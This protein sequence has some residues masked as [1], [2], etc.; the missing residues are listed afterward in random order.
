[1]IWRDPY[2]PDIAIPESLR[3][4]WFKLGD[5]RYQLLPKQYE[6]IAGPEESMAFIGGYGSGKTRV[7]TIKAAA[8]SCFT[9]SNRGIV[10]RLNGTDLEETTQRDLLDFLHE[11]K[12]LK[13]EPNAR[14]H[15]ALVHCI[16]EK[17]GRNLGLD[18][19][20][21]FQHLDDPAHLRGRHV[22]WVWI[23]EGSEVKRAAWQNLIGRMRL[24]S[25]RGRYRAF[26]TGNP[27]GH[28]WIYDFFFDEAK[29]K[30]ITCGG[31]PGAH[32]PMCVDHDDRKC[33]KRLRLQRR[34]IHCTSYENYFLPPEY[35]ESM[36]NSF[37][38]DERKRYVEASFDVFEGQVFKEFSHQTHVIQAPSS[39]PLGR[40]PK[41][42][43]RLLACDVGG[44]SPWSFEWCAVDPD[45]NIVFYD[46]IYEIT[47]NVDRLVEK[48]LPKMVDE[49]GQQYSFRSKVID[50]ENK[51]AAEDL[52]RRGITF[53]NAA[54]M[55]KAGSVARLSSYLHPNEKHHFPGWHPRAGQPN[56]PRLFIVGTGCPSLVRELPQQRWKE[57]LT[58]ERMKDEMDRTIANHATDCC[59][60]TVRELPEVA[61]LPP[62]PG[63][64][65][66]QKDLMS[67]LYWEDVKRHEERQKQSSVSRPY[68]IRPFSI[69]MLE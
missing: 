7:G 51:I 53:T 44:A 34:A 27:E 38:A 65:P 5:A 10:G 42:W 30:T 57:D 32:V 64:T 43:P 60:Y 3:T 59:L 39:W 11:A 41:E 40:P 28:N 56:A 20:I 1:M 35:I 23:D 26:V 62:S 46:E 21:S 52:R 15:R 48:A 13:E 24:P 12:L 63:F 6:F 14:N 54:K 69:D 47:T 68:R 55:G 22:G 37:S 4:D 61:K 67:A 66:K 9:P 50:Y 8:I 36:V 33:N 29:L 2:I 25:Y 58:N 31:E 49:D 18:S 16:D 19:E 17:T 45:N